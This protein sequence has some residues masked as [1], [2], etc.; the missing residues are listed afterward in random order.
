LIYKKI[1]LALVLLLTIGL[2]IAAYYYLKYFYQSPVNAQ[3]GVNTYIYIKPTDNFNAVYKQLIEK[4]MLSDTNAFLWLSDKMDLEQ[5]LKPGRYPILPGMSTYEIITMIRSGKQEPVKLVIGKFRLAAQFKRFISKQLNV[6][7][8]AL[9]QSFDSMLVARGQDTSIVSRQMT[10]YILPNTYEF[11]WNTTPTKFW[12]KLFKA[13]DNYWNVTRRQQADAIN[14]TPYQVYCL[15]AIV[16]EETSKNDEKP[17]IAGVYLNRLKIGMPLQADPT[18]KFALNDFTLKRILYSHLEVVSPYN[19]Y[20]V[21]GLPPGP[22][23]IPSI[24]S[25]EAVLNYENHNYVY[26]CAK[27]DFSGYHNFATTLQGHDVNA[28]NYQ[29]AYREKFGSKQNTFESKNKLDI[30]DMSQQRSNV[31]NIRR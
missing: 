25:I 17:I 23:C 31:I 22:I 2:S 5:L 11:W 7:S 24:A 14:M 20:K 29:Q 9:Q 8:I 21:S 30:L 13:Y 16:E 19:T 27:D 28:K 10:A 18:I 12:H 15:A 4:Q 3:L 6:D 1:L 26:F